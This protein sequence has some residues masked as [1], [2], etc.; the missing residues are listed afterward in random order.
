MAISTVKADFQNDIEKV[1]DTVTSLDNY[2]W[3]SD[4]SKID[5]VN[6]S[7]FIEYTTDGYATTFTVTACEPL[8]C[9][10][11]DLKNSNMTGHWTGV[12]FYKDG[13]TTIEFTEDVSPKKFL[14]KPFVK[15]FLKK[16][17]QRYIKDL[18]NV[19][20]KHI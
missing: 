4:L 5:V 2:Q 17:Q 7:E 18:R 1:W 15:S 8:K 6:E 3:R 13:I 9:W 19:L 16:Q 20:E 10:E 14:L 12:F 11:F